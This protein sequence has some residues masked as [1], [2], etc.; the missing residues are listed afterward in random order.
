MTLT[1]VIWW[2]LNVKFVS[3]FILVLLSVAGLF[4]KCILLTCA[5][6]YWWY[7]LV[8]LQVVIFRMLLAK[9][10]PWSSSY[11]KNA[12]KDLS[13]KVTNHLCLCAWNGRDTVQN[14][15]ENLGQ[16]WIYPH[17]IWCALQRLCCLL[18]NKK[19]SL[20]LFCNTSDLSWWMSL[21]FEPSNTQGLKCTI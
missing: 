1:I 11:K 9:Q 2:G 7:Y 14:K 18:Y 5:W 16:V 19:A 3:S 6:H 4:G 17:V 10:I 15:L 12:W 13:C 8:R 21:L 20:T